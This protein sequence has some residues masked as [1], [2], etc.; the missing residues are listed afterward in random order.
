MS[1]DTH[2][3]CSTGKRFAF[4]IRNVLFRL[5]VTVLLCHAKVNDVNN[6]GT[7][8]TRP[9]NEEVIWLDVSVNQVLLMDGLYS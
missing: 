8:G 5:R 9:A 3:A 6:V 2:I 1:V 7:L 4:S